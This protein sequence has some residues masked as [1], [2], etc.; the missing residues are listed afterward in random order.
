VAAMQD[1]KNAADQK[2][3]KKLSEPNVSKQESIK[4]SK[5]EEKISLESM[6]KE[7]LITREEYERMK[8]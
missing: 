1:R 5:E 7:G 2:S 6:L 3:E 8:K 4:H